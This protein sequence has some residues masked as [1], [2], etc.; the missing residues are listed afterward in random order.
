MTENQPG[1]KFLK[2]EPGTCGVDKAKPHFG[3][4]IL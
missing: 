2:D 4:P 3:D 1:V